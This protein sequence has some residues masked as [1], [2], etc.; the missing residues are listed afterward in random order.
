M[1]LL[2]KILSVVAISIGCLL[3]TFAVQSQE[4]QKIVAIVNDDVI[5]GY[6]V[7]QR[8]NLNIYMAGLPANNQTRQQ[9]VPSVIKTLIDEQLKIQEAKRRNTEAND[10]EI[11]KAIEVFEKRLKILPG[12]FDETLASIRVNPEAVIHQIRAAVGWDKLIRRR[13][14]PRI[15]VTES[16]IKSK[17]EE[18]RANKGKNEYLI[19]EIFMPIEISSK[20]QEV[21]KSADNLAGQLKKGANFSRVAAQF[22]EGSTAANG[23]LVGWQMAEE[24]PQE[25]AAAV[26]RMDTG[27]ISD[28]I[29]TR[30]GYYIVEVEDIRK[31]LGDTTS[32]AVVELEQIAIPLKA[33]EATNSKDSQITLAKS[34]SGFVNGCEYLPELVSGMANS[35]SGKMGQVQLSNLPDKFRGLIENLE[36]GQASEPF[37][38]G[39]IYRIFVVCKRN[40][41]R[42]QSDSEEA[43]RNLI[44]GKRIESRARRYMNDLR[45]EA[46]IET[47]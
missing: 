27:N 7:I 35:Q 40:D 45:R 39:D 9:L 23:G 25:I 32:D 12:K 38:D 46:S 29:R 6:D 28:P 18:L 26:I 36:E 31:I 1:K 22:S 43:I 37:L 2:T 30:D 44:G 8:I 13:I 19:K 47:R 41:T 15:N 3:P 21:R 11:N 4:V 34:I 24:M 33:A 5:S 16:E 14:V 20:E 10:E 17:Q 42:K